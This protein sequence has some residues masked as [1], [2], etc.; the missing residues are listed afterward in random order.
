MNKVIQR[1]LEIVG[2]QK[3]LADICGV[4]R[5]TSKWVAKIAL[6]G[7]HH[8]IGYFHDLKLAVLAYNA[9]CERLHG[10]YGKRK[11][12]HN[13]NKLREMGLL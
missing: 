9:E 1:A 3:R 11:I 8:H 6:A 13:L 12:D 10:E 4:S 2:S 7:K 5:K